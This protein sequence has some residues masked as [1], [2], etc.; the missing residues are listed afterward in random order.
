MQS[1]YFFGT[2]LSGGRDKVCYWLASHLKTKGNPRRRGLAWGVLWPR[3]GRGNEGR[4][5]A[6]EARGEASF[7]V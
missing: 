5:R 3:Y 7:C 1:A 4:K 6:A 2:T